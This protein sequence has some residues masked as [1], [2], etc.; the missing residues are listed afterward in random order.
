MDD[1]RLVRVGI[2]PV[3]LA[4]MRPG[5]VCIK[6]GLPVDARATNVFSDPDRNMFFVIMEHESFAIVP[7]GEMIPIV[8]GPVFKDSS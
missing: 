6:N 1:R 4:F 3:S 8:S 2:C 7:E 5:T